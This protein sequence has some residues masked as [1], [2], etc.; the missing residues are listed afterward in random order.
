MIIII[1][2]WFTI[3]TNHIFIFVILWSLSVK[4]CEP[5]IGK[6]RYGIKLTWWWQ[7]SFFLR[8]ANVVL[9]DPVS[10]TYLSTYL[11]PELHWYYRNDPG[12]PA[13]LYEL[14]V[15]SCESGDIICFR[16]IPRWWAMVRNWW[17]CERGLWR[18]RPQSHS[19]HREDWGDDSDS[20][21]ITILWEHGGIFSGEIS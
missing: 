17:E 1:V 18:C 7:W 3:I 21:S 11:G 13:S 8:S 14:L 15:Q 9:H 10:P 5:R 19:S 12:W 4:A 16:R 20:D 2:L 6:P